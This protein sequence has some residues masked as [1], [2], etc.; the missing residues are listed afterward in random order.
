V[1]SRSDDW[2]YWTLLLQLELIITTHTL[3]SFVTTSVCSISMKNLSLLSESRI[4]LS[5]SGSPL[6]S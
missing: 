4:G 3:N 1:G 5:N 6:T 2:I